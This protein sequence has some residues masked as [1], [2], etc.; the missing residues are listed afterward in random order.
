MSETLTDVQLYGQQKFEFEFTLNNQTLATP[1]TLHKQGIIEL[2]I[3]EKMD[4]LMDQQ[5][6]I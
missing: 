2:V 5:K 4:Y 3:V 6:D 1:T